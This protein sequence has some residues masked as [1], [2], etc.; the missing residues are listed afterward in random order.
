MNTF[1]DT[2]DIEP[3][4]FTYLTPVQ[5]DIPQTRI[6]SKVPCGKPRH[7]FTDVEG[8]LLSEYL[9]KNPKMTFLFETTGDSMRDA[10][11]NEG[12]IVAVDC[13]LEPKHGN[14]VLAEVNGELTL[15]RICIMRDS[16]TGEDTVTL[17]PEN[18]LH[19]P[20]ILADF[21]DFRIFGVATS[22][23]RI[24]KLT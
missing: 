15:K 7:V 20:I 24:E 3:E 11:I 9:S 23:M 16:V 19:K 14:I 22:K 17:M 12:D 6:C 5:F 4:A 8:K 2:F 21:D 10:G 13:R 18:P 1:M